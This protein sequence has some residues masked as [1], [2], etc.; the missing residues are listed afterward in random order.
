MAASDRKR[1][2]DG[3][4]HLASQPEDPVHII[5]VFHPHLVHLNQK[6]LQAGQPHIPGIVVVVFAGPLDRAVVEKVGR[7]TA[8]AAKGRFEIDDAG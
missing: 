8:E 4:L 3:P 5:T 1:R 7:L 2:A 6:I